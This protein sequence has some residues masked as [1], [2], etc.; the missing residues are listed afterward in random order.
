MLRES[1][2]F[3][4]AGDPRKGGN[5]GSK[6]RHGILDMV[7]WTHVLGPHV[8]IGGQNLT[9]WY[10]GHNT[11]GL[12]VRC[13][14]T[15]ASDVVFHLV[16]LELGAAQQLIQHQTLKT[17]NVF[18]GRREHEAIGQWML[19]MAPGAKRTW[20]SHLITH[21]TS[22]IRIYVYFKHQAAATGFRVLPFTSSTGPVSISAG[23][24]EY[25]T[26]TQARALSRPLNGVWMDAL[27]FYS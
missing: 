15:R 17:V 1:P 2:S 23:S 4:D 16:L 27:C 10:F 18:S 20:T 11:T 7:F 25:F 21:H 5:E 6:P 26:C 22:R 13:R 19:P 14:W 8:I 24:K 12:V 9:A 3:M